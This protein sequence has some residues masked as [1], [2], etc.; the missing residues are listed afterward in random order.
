SRRNRGF[1]VIRNAR[2]ATLRK[3]S[4]TW[5]GLDGASFAIVVHEPNLV[6]PVRGDLAERLRR[7]RVRQ[8]RYG[9]AGP[10]IRVV[11]RE[12]TGGVPEAVEEQAAPLVGEHASSLAPKTD[13]AGSMAAASA[14]PG[15]KPNQRVD[16][17]HCVLPET[18]LTVHSGHMV[19]TI[20]HLGS[21]PDAVEGV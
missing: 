3:M 21:D 5:T 15:Q 11:G 2:L 1:S 8:P 7:P 17:S 16:A 6:Q 9:K 20:G 12:R 10:T 19:Y 4:G 18:W 13:R 14:A